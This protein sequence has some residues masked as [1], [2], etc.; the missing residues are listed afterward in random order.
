MRIVTEILDDNGNLKR[1]K[2]TH[3]FS[4]EPLLTEQHHKD[5][6]DINKIIRKHG[7]DI[8]AKTASLRSAE[9]KFDDIPGNDFE[10]AMRIV[11][12]AQSTFEQLP[13]Q[14]RA[15]FENSPAKYL[16]YIQNP[17]NMESMIERGWAVRR[18]ENEPIEVIVKN[19]P[20]KVAETP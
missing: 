8:I 10:E 11:A 2:V 16:D 12:R 17:D 18:P 19:P 7:M 13:S 6:V 1:R 20:P 5:N 4:D 15:E 9:Y 3:D 14:I